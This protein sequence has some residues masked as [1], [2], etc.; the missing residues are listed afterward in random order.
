MGPVRTRVYIRAREQMIERNR[1]E[2]LNNGVVVEGVGVRFRSG[3]LLPVYPFRWSA[4]DH[5]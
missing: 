4:K 2:D 3:Y 1:V 5:R